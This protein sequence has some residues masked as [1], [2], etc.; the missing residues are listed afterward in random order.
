MSEGFGDG[1]LLGEDEGVHEILK[2]CD[3]IPL[4]GEVGKLFDRDGIVHI[5]VS[6]YDESFVGDQIVHG[7]YKSLLG[8]EIALQDLDLEIIILDALIEESA[9]FRDD[10]CLLHQ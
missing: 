4:P 8:L 9:E 2:F 5:E 6:R 10:L 3:I 7:F 1:Y